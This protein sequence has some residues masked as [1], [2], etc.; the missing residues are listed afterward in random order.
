MIVWT[1]IFLIIQAIN[2]V[3]IQY[4]LLTITASFYLLN[5]RWG[6]FYSVLILIPVLVYFILNGINYAQVIVNP[7]QAGN[8][9]FMTVL[10]FNFS[11]M[12]FINYHFLKAFHYALFKLSE[13]QKDEKQLNERLKEAISH[14]EGSSKAKSDFLSTMSHE[15]RTPLNSVIGMSYVLLADKPREDQAENLKVLHFSAESLLALINDILDFNK[16][17]YGNIELER[18]GFYP[19]EQI[20]RIYTGLK[21]QADER[22]LSFILDLDEDLRDV[23][24]IGD[25]TR[26]LQILFNLAGNAI[27]F[28][29]AG[30][31]E[32]SVNI[33]RSDNEYITLAFS[34]K[35][36][37][38]GIAPDQREVIFAPFTQ[39]SNN[40]TR[41][42][43]GTRLGLA[44]TKQILDLHASTIELISEVGNGTSFN[45]K[46]TYQR[47]SREEVADNSSFLSQSE[48]TADISALDVLV[49]EDNTMNVLLMKKL[50]LSWNISADFAENGS[51]AL[52]MA[53]NKFYDI[54]LMDIHMPVM[55][56]YDASG[57]IL[58]FYELQNKK[59]WIIALTASV[60]NDIYK[61]IKTAG[62]NDY[63]SKPFNP[64]DLKNKFINLSKIRSGKIS[65]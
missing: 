51:I 16:L 53:T 40:I 48:A 1:N 24:I 32:L 65:A 62:M 9:A 47:A 21:Y 44:I 18:T 43:G 38:I 8:P 11:L 42:F 3:T 59:P 15:L 49:A 2:I 6:M 41:K 57:R 26:L 46:I 31:I 56:G 64:S 28:T 63:I 14:A 36:T 10:V 50:F 60:A 4:I 25:P 45:F 23:A 20:R 17:E 58:E 5:S 35:D 33:I 19:E 27:K 37:G 29:P 34:V 22:G 55:D 12:I 13:A 54:I 30:T 52:E 61:K 39:A 7:Q